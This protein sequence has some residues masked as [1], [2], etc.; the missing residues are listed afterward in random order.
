MPSASAARNGLSTLPV[1][2]RRR[3][4]RL[5]KQRG[6]SPLAILVQALR[7]A[8]RP[9]AGTLVLS[10]Y[11]AAKLRRVAQAEGRDPEQLVLE[12]LTLSEQKRE[13]RV[14]RLGDGELQEKLA[15]LLRSK[16]ASLERLLKLGLRAFL[17]QNP[18]LT[19]DEERLQAQLGELRAT[20]GRNV[21]AELLYRE[22]TN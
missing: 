18:S 9:K 2:A 5:S 21:P 8:E 11:T 16:K 12:G 20:L 6:E 7:E 13:G 10:K 22:K 15:P 19:E 1:S 14:F 3:L 4:R 17:L